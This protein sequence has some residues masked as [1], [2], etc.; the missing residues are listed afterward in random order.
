MKHSAFP[1]PHFLLIL[2]LMSCFLHELFAATKY[3]SNSGSNGNTG[4]SWAQAWQT[5][6]YGADHINAGDTLWVANG[7]YVGFDMRTTGT[8]ANPIVFIAAGNNVVINLPTGTT[9][10]IN[11]EDADYIEIKGFRVINLPRNGI[12]LVHADHCI[13]RNNYCESNFERGIFTGFTDDILIEY[14]ECLTSDDEHGI[15]VSNS[16]DRSIIRYNICHHNHGGGIQI[17]ADISQGGD[18]IST[19]PE[20]YGNVIYENG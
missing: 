7:T 9:D 12:R 14:N 8:A 15:Y 6:Q 18:G 10:G 3:A 16:S 5:L 4:N 1:P 20:I 19:D 11:V 17:N 13:V 2:F